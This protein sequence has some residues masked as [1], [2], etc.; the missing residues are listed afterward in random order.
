M[1]AA[2]E[3]LIRV[4]S[5]TLRV[6]VSGEGR[7]VLLINGLGAS[8]P[9][10]TALLE[11]LH[12]MQVIAFDAPGSGQSPAPRV[13]YRIRDL[14][15]LATGLLDRFGHE[16]ADVV[17]YS[18]GGVVAQELAHRAPDRVGRLVLAATM[19]GWGGVPA[20][21]SAY[22]AVGT[23]LRY[24][25]KAAYTLSMPLLGDSPREADAGFIQRT[26]ATRLLSPPSVAG[27]FLQLAAGWGWTSLPWLH[28]V[29]HPTLVI[30][31]TADRLVPVAN[32]YLLAGRLPN[33][34]LLLFEDWG[35]LLLMD[36]SSGTGAMI[37]EFLRADGLT[38]SAT[39]EGAQ[40]VSAGEI[41]AS[42]RATP[43]NGHPAGVYNH[44]LRRLFP[45]PRTR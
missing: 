16:R 18:L 36:R 40:A 30:A 26:A 42:I 43:G 6:H 45:A 10:W 25:S 41:A 38:D 2:W 34:R 19:C 4:G 37:G 29:E 9:M 33:A 24:Y 22:L 5:R 32:A 15:R 8:L 39:W 11:D 21:L 17:G 27:Y 35:H 1:S 23:P 12:G 28:R 44:L 3:D 7:P 20:P 31:G 14:V 13:P